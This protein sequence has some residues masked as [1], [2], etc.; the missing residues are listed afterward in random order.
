MS[1]DS[2]WIL[3]TNSS[4]TS[5]VLLNAPKDISISTNFNK[6]YF[7]R[8]DCYRYR[9]KFLK[10][11]YLLHL[12]YIDIFYDWGEDKAGEISA[13]GDMSKY[14]NWSFSILRF[15]GR[16][17]LHSGL[18]KKNSGCS[19]NNVNTFVIIFLFHFPANG[20]A[21]LKQTI[22]I[23]LV[24]HMWGKCRQFESSTV[25]PWDLS[26]RDY[27]VHLTW[28][29]MKHRGIH[30]GTKSHSGKSVSVEACEQATILSVG[31][32]TQIKN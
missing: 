16:F 28:W 10:S 26:L 31:T 23:Y 2:Y 15:L 3:W 13:M 25:F 7:F 11:H 5:V 14:P 4:I 30:W 17:N 32:K 19:H 20:D 21:L 22:F 18:I 29:Q 27:M 24:I 6:S 8:N 12:N 9:D 1:Q